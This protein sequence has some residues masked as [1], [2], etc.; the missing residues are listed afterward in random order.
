MV[1]EGDCGSDRRNSL[2]NLMSG[3]ELWVPV[4]GLLDKGILSISLCPVELGKNTDI[5]LIFSSQLLGYADLT[6]R[7]FL[8]QAFS[9]HS[10]PSVEPFY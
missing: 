7:L 5:P 6:S 9:D 10:W 3:K 8:L 2:L 4:A 1:R